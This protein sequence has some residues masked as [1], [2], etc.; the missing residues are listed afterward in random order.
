MDDPANF[1]FLQKCGLP[2]ISPENLRADIRF[3]KNMDFQF[4]TFEDLRKNPGLHPSKPSVILSFDDGYKDNYSNART[5]LENEGVR[6]VFF[7]TTGI[8]NAESL[9]WAHTIFWHC[10]DKENYQ[11]FLAVCRECFPEKIRD[12]ENRSLNLAYYL[13]EEVGHSKALQALRL[14]Q[15]IFPKSIE[16]ELSNKLYPD[17]KDI[18]EAHAAGH[19]I[20]CHGDQH[21][22]RESISWD[23]FENDLQVSV[24]K[25][26]KW[27]GQAPKTYAYPH[28]NFFETDNGVVSK[29]FSQ[30]VTVQQGIISKDAMPLNLNRFYWAGPP[31][32][33][34]R[35]KRWLL[36]GTC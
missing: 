25:I 9:L 36:T 28:G 14:A 26:T 10:R 4:I 8:V 21:L 7:Q 1:P 29:Y 24:E 32:N 18:Q 16:R 22:K 12:M 3:L 11:K 20:A 33:E 35:R 15:E 2:V 13:T 34:L 19:E 17:V 31:K 30:V 27:T 6:G 23:V 5:I